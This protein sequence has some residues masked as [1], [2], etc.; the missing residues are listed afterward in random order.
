MLPQNV[1]NF[2]YQQIPAQPQKLEKILSCY[3]DVPSHK[4][5]PTIIGKSPSKLIVQKSVSCIVDPNRKK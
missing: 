4:R 5:D 2:I 1:K 3:L